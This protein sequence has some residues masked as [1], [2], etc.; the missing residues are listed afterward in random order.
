MAASKTPHEAEWKTRKKRIDPRLDAGGWPRRSSPPSPKPFRTEE[1]ETANGPANYALWIDN[2]IVGIVE[3]KKLTVGP[4]NVLTQPARY[5][6]GLDP[7]VAGGGGDELR[8]CEP[9]GQRG[10]QGR[11]ANLLTVI[12]PGFGRP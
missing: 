9:C 7:S 1:E 11:A 10:S 5:A 6:R 8:S 4:Q 12:T 3:A 2:Q